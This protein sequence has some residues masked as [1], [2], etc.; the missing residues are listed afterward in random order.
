M[1]NYA[2]DEKNEETFL[3]GKIFTS[4]ISFIVSPSLMFNSN[5]LL[6]HR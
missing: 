1:K 2:V 5:C 3:E 6:S 4:A